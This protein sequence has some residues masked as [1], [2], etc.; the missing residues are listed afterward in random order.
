MGRRSSW[1]SR[2][3]TTPACDTCR[4]SV[5]RVA[6]DVREK[7]RRIAAKLL[8]AAAPDV[9]NVPGGFQ[10]VG[11]PQRRVTWKEVASAAYAGGQALPAGETPGLE[12]STYFQPEGEVWSFGAV[13]C[14]VRVEGET[15]RLSIERLVWVD[16]AGTVIN[17]LLAEGQLHG[18]LA[19]GLGQALLDRKS[20]RLNS[21][22]VASSYA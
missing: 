11:V 20:T 22:H 8:E 7:G 12:A 1:R 4:R 21:S 6:G 9:V 14:A 18:A 16:D 3:R 19:Q 10:V 5:A 15:G 17:P 13:V 2:R